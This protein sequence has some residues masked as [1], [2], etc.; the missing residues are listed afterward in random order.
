MLL[1]A[2]A[3][4]LA[5]PAPDQAPGGSANGAAFDWAAARGNGAAPAA[6][7][8]P[9]PHANVNGAHV[10]GLLNGVAADGHGAS[11]AGLVLPLQVRFVGR[12]M[13]L[14]APPPCP[15]SFQEPICVTPL[16]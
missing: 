4:V 6:H 12:C 14:D 9:S 2:A 8:T 5:G 1:T 7:P 10:A 11:E 3:A 13:A 15:V 16:I